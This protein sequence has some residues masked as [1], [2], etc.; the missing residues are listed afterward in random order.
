MKIR[1]LTGIYI[2]VLAMIVFLVDRS[3]TQHLFRFI[4]NVPGAD[5]IGHFCLMGL[6][7]LL[8]NLAFSARTIKIWK[9]NLPLGSLIVLFVVVIEEFS[10][11][12]VSGRTFDLGDL[13]FDFAGILMFGELARLIVNR[14]KRKNLIGD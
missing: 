7:S 12:F 14:Q 8:L 11:I 9:I 5:K 2:F 1:I 13:L 6:F 4:Y 3:E 10:Q